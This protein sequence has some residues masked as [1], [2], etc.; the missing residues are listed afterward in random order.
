[1]E[2]A[3]NEAKQERLEKVKKIIGL[4]RIGTNSSDAPQTTGADWNPFEN[5]AQ[6]L[7]VAV[8]LGIEIHHNT[9][10]LNGCWVSAEHKASGE[11]EI[12]AVSGPSFS[13]RLRATKHAIV[14]VASRLYAE[15]REMDFGGALNR[16]RGHPVRSISC[17]TTGR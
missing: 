9:H 16:L 8:Y 11:L 13:E 2:N 7:E 1:M 3:T 12:V 5:A 6:A 15:E 17:L 4:T 14:M 10:T